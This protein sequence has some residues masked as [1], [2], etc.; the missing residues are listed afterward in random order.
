MANGYKFTLQYYNNIQNNDSNSVSQSTQTKR[1]VK[2]FSLLARLP[3][4]R[5]YIDFFLFFFSL[6]THLAYEMAFLFYAIF[7]QL[8]LFIKHFI[9]SILHANIETTSKSALL[10]SFCVARS[11][12][13]VAFLFT[14]IHLSAQILSNAFQMQ[15]YCTSSPF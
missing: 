10:Q 2:I 8:F 9:I 7:M 6:K 13:C 12:R 5:L 4:G 15:L 1:E 3:L 14:K 11:K